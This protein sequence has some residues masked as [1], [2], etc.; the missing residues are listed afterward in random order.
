MSEQSGLVD[1]HQDEAK[2]F[3]VPL[4]YRPGLKF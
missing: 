2:Q 3:Q 4:L 1:G